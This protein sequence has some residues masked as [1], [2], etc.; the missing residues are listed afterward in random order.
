[1][2]T[3]CYKSPET[4]L[5]IV[6][7]GGGVRLAVTAID[8]GDDMLVTLILRNKETHKLRKK[9]ISKFGGHY[10]IGGKTSFSALRTLCIFFFPLP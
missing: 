6:V 3:I 1:M 8:G 4:L 2:P 7:V 10:G 5:L 9:N